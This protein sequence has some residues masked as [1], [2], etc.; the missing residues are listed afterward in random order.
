M[1]CFRNNEHSTYQHGSP[2]AVVAAVPSGRQRIARED[3]RLYNTDSKQARD[4]VDEKSED[5]GV[6][7]EREHAVEQSQPPQFA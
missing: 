3:T 7:A 6:K 5:N 1:G 2:P 4:G